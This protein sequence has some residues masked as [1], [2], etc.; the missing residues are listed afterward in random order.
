MSID[1]K[2]PTLS[3]PDAATAEKRVVAPGQANA[4]IKK[5]VVG[6][7]SRSGQKNIVVQKQTSGLLWLTLAIT[8][9]A[10]VVACSA[11]WQSY[12][13]QSAFVLQQKRIVEL[14]DKL[15][16][17]GGESEQSLTALSANIKRLQKD[18]KLA[19]S[20]TDKLWATRN[21]NRQAIADI[22]KQLSASMDGTNQ[23][24]KSLQQQ[25]SEQELLIQ[26]VRESQ[27]DQ[28]QTITNIHQ[29]LAG[30]ASK[31]DLTE[32][33]QKI[34]SHDEAVESFDKFRLSVNRDLITLKQRLTQPNTAQ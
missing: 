26:S 25:S 4:T 22:Q 30:Y 17:A 8:L 29:E 7:D 15:A 2:E 9:L 11:L 1:R 14:E 24:L 5:P 3:N 28:R 34:Q 33:Q 21:V 20:E 31:S 10:V 16:L 19:L 18:I 23:S 13:L 6:R 32:L 12:S 27:S